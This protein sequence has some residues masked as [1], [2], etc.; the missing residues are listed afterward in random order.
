MPLPLVAETTNFQLVPFITVLFPDIRVHKPL[1]C[2]GQRLSNS[3]L[4]VSDEKCET[5][6]MPHCSYTIHLPLMLD[7]VSAFRYRVG[8]H[9]P[10]EQSVEI[11]SGS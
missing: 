2:T 10:A 5:C 7:P 6:R 8:P 1:P 11:G 9:F 4:S 3:R